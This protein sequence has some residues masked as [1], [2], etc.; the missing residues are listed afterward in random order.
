MNAI[1]K[2]VHALLVFFSKSYRKDCEVQGF[3]VE[4]RVKI[5][6][7]GYYRMH[8]GPQ[9]IRRFVR[10]ETTELREYLREIRRVDPGAFTQAIAI[11][12]DSNNVVVLGLAVEL[13]PE[14]G[15]VCADKLMGF[16][17]QNMRF[18]G[19]TDRAMWAKSE[20]LLAREWYERAE[21]LT[22][23]REYEIEQ[24]LTALAWIG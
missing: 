8:N 3:L 2:L 21:E 18:C 14:V 16:A 10:E 15:A 6:A 20:M 23:A 11:L 19:H 4:L 1:Q 12:V 5:G 7:Y 22:R 13:S 24:G 9:E 17:R